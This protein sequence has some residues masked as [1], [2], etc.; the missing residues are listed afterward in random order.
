MLGLTFYKI[1][2]FVFF[3]LHDTL[4]ISR[5][6]LVQKQQ[7]FYPSPLWSNFRF[8]TWTKFGRYPIPLM[9]WY[10]TINKDEIGVN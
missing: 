9:K 6:T 10:A 5:H 8:H 1:S 4:R 7:V 2:L 3:S